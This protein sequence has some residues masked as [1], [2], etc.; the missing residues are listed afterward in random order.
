MLAKGEIWTIRRCVILSDANVAARL[1]FC[2]G[3]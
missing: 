3:V 1:E 2:D